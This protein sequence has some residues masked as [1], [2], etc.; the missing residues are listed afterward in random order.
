MR[1]PR[2]RFAIVAA[3]GCSAALAVRAQQPLDA[4][5]GLAVGALA[6]LTLIALALLWQQ[7]RLRADLHV[8]WSAEA[9]RRASV[10]Q[11]LADARSHLRKLAARQDDLMERERRRI[12]R[13]IHDDLGQNLL[14]LKIDIGMLQASTGTEAAAPHQKL[15]FIART[16][17]L[18]IKSLRCIIHDLHPIALQ[19]GLRAAVEMQ[20]DDFARMNAIECK[21]NA[22]P[23]VFDASADARLDPI[24]FRI[25][26]E[27][28]SN[29]AR[30]ANATA[31][32]VALH[33]S[34]DALAMTVSDNGVGLP[35]DALRRGC[36]LTGIEDRVKAL[37][38]RFFIDS[39]PGQ[40]SALSLSI[41]LAG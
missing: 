34:A 28:L 10:E 7:S 4:T 24:V 20:L 8:C 1:L 14:A 26:Q 41:P 30:H 38:G 21:F 23:G 6:L 13:D 35:P 33:R 22:D 19:A 25:L 37:G 32:S 12:A 15:E 18:S 29:I 9:S 31:V 2:Y 3:V 17:D 39:G 27:S 36:G 5:A 16:I 11:A 40:G